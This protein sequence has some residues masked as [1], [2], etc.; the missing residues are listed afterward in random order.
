[1]YSLRG[2]NFI[3]PRFFPRSP[4]LWYLIFFPYLRNKNDVLGVGPGYSFR[5]AKTVTRLFFSWYQNYHNCLSLGPVPKFH[6]VVVYCIVHLFCEP[7][8]TK[9]YHWNPTL[10]YRH[11][12]TINDMFIWKTFHLFFGHVC[13]FMSLMVARCL[14]NK[15][16]FQWY[17]FVLCGSQKRYA[18]RW[19]SNHVT[20]VRAA[21]ARWHPTAIICTQDGA[22]PTWSLFAMFKKCYRCSRLNGGLRWIFTFRRQYKLKILALRPTKLRLSKSGNIFRTKEHGKSRP[23]G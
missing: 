10:L 18:T 7:H 1:M 5:A 8:K 17:F 3:S 4:R 20:D 13:P 14:Y 15:V 11:L 23:K 12:A 22:A 19:R 9:K 16:G 6:H 2:E 21:N